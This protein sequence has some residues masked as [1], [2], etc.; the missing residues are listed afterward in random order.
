M[1]ASIASFEMISRI[2]TSTYRLIA[3]S[4][5]LLYAKALKK[6]RKHCGGIVPPL[7]L[8]FA[9]LMRMKRITMRFIHRL[10]QLARP[11]SHTRNNT[12]GRTSISVSVVEMRNTMSSSGEC[13]VLMILDDPPEEKIAL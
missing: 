4:L 2:I 13:E 1:Y 11:N 3:A 12:N 5:L 6:E 9:L 7:Y 10:V 8:M